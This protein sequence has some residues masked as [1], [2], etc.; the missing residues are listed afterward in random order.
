MVITHIRCLSFQFRKQCKRR[1]ATCKRRIVTNNRRLRMTLV[2][3]HHPHLFTQQT[4]LNALKS[5]RASFRILSFRLLSHSKSC[6]GSYQVAFVHR[7]YL[8]KLHVRE[9]TL[10]ICTWN[11]L[12]ITDRYSDINRAAVHQ[13]PGSLATLG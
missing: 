5:L 12:A 10:R 1:I 11:R 13:M 6:Q 7:K 9:S 3:A 8:L 4:N 2:G